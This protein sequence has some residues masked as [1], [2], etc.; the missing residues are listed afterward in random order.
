MLIII[1]FVPY[2]EVFFF[3][4][5]IHTCFTLQE[6]KEKLHLMH[7]PLSLQTQSTLTH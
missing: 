4:L 6:K 1:I 2:L 5:L 3:L 7:T